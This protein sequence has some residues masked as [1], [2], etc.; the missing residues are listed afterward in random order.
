MFK[1]IDW[2]LAA[3]CWI[4]QSVAV[5][6]HKVSVVRGAI[7]AMAWAKASWTPGLDNPLIHRGPGGYLCDQARLLVGN[8]LWHVRR[9]ETLRAHIV[10]T[11]LASAAGGGVHLARKASA[12]GD[13]RG[14]RQ[15]ATG[16]HNLVAH[17]L[18]MSRSLVFGV[19][20]GFDREGWVWKL[21]KHKK[22]K[23][24]GKGKRRSQFNGGSHT[25]RLCHETLISTLATG[26]AG[27]DDEGRTDEVSGLPTLPIADDDADET[28]LDAESELDGAP[29][30]PQP[31]RDM[32]GTPQLRPSHVARR[33][34][35]VLAHCRFA[36]R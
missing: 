28:F 12:T 10:E 16:V 11:M 23:V 3:A 6:W 22:A 17:L 27:G 34:V 18:G 35:S 29:P 8:L 25:A 15:R 20:A 1:R 31:A 5:F 14:G 30:Q 24:S 9:S 4:S 33:V 2:E 13:G 26:N 32:E 36:W 7:G 21:H 19:E